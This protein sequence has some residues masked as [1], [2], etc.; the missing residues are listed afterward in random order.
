MSEQSSESAFGRGVSHPGYLRAKNEDRYLI[1]DDLGLYAVFD[2]MGGHSGGDVAAALARDVIVRYVGDKRRRRPPRKVLE[3]A[4]QQASSA[5]HREAQRR[6]AADAMGT[7]AVAVLVGPS[8]RGILASVGDSRAYL[9]RDG[10]LRL[11]TRDQTIVNELVASGSLSP[12]AAA[13]HP[14]RSV[15]SNNLGARPRTHVQLAD[16]E[17]EPGD[18]LLLCSDGLTGFASAESIAAA[19][20]GAADPERAAGDLVELALEGGG[21]DNVT[22]VVVEVGRTDSARTSAE[23]RRSGAEAW[24]R[25]RKR[26]V[27]A[28]R[29]RGL[30]STQLGALV[31]ADEVVALIGGDFAEACARDLG[32]ARLQGVERFAEKLASGWLEQGGDHRALAELFDVLLAAST[33]VVA[34]M[35]RDGDPLADAVEAEVYRALAAAEGAVG[36][37]LAARLRAASA[38]VDEMRR[39]R[40]A[41]EQSARVE[42]GRVTI[43]ADAAVPAAPAPEVAKCLADAA[44]KARGE[45]GSKGE[46]SALESVQRVIAFEAGAADYRAVAE[47][48]AGRRALDEASASGLFAA[49]DRAREAHTAAA[50]AGAADATA[51][52]AAMV[53]VSVGYQRVA[54]AVAAMAVCAGRAVAEELASIAAEVEALRADVRRGEARLERLEEEIAELSGQL[55]DTIVSSGGEG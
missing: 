16:L 42:A 46:R 13:K 48:L 54:A 25:R 37:L 49:L 44:V 50:R 27:D 3:R 17:L 12:A 11:L 39:A 31:P 34:D 19:T 18:R 23:V 26:F 43:Q 24:W 5:V 8:R 14:Y 4:F 9:V 45:L 10:A 21:G 30:S 52:A 28:A 15:L 20:V 29:A 33:D 36:R 40:E 32:G 53:R 22:A 6:E 7:T 35:R 55:V 2:G 38:E 51:R 41:R 1:D 47:E